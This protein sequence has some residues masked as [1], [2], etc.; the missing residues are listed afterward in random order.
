MDLV[1]LSLNSDSLGQS[2]TGPQTAAHLRTLNSVRLCLL[3]ALPHHTAGR[4]K[5]KL[6]PYFNSRSESSHK[7]YGFADRPPQTSTAPFL[8]LL[9]CSHGTAFG[10]NKRQQRRL[11]SVLHTLDLLGQLDKAVI[12]TET[13]RCWFVLRD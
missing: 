12:A 9:D 10:D 8:A 5:L 7:R 4:N 2:A 6:A 11:I 13:I 3:R 1:A